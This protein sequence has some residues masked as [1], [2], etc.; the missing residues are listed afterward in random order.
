MHE[1]KTTEPEADSSAD[2]PRLSRAARSMAFLARIFEQVSLD[3]GISLPQ[4]RLLVFL[5]HGPKRAG[6]LAARAAIKRPTLTALVDALEKEQRLQRIADERDGRGVRIEMTEKGH[7]DLRGVEEALASV[8]KEVCALGEYE[9][10][11]STIDRLSERLDVEF[12]K[13]M[14]E[15]KGRWF[16]QGVD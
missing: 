1:R 12:E 9:E 3:A 13:R 16:G 5:R 14:K 4:Y 10:T 8:V 2:D 15:S 6:E 7:S 11:L